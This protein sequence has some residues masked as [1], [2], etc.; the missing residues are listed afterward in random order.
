MH[1]LFKPSQTVISPGTCSHSSARTVVH[2]LR[3]QD[4][5]DVCCGLSAGGRIHDCAD[6]REIPVGAAELTKACQPRVNA[7]TNAEFAP[8]EA[9]ALRQETS[10]TSFA[11]PLDLA[12][13]QYRT[14]GMV[15]VA[16]RKVEHRHDGIANRFVEDAIVLPDRFCALI[17]ERVEQ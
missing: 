14:L 9:N 10:P 5:T 11:P 2:G 17:V 6:C 1:R 15:L 3:D 4:L 8:S 16:D 12:P 7:D 13:G